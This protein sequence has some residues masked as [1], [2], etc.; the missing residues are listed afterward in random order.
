MVYATSDTS[1]TLSEQEPE[2]ADDEEEE[3]PQ[4]ISQESVNTRCGETRFQGDSELRKFVAQHLTSIDFFNFSIAVQNREVEDLK[5]SNVYSKR[6][7][8]PLYLS[9]RM[10]AS[11]LVLKPIRPFHPQ[12]NPDSRKCSLSVQESNPSDKIVY[13]LI[14]TSRSSSGLS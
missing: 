11:R 2:L 14:P 3:K 7:A 6:P 4:R 8:G 1:I 12:K 9:N 5:L 13:V 10:K